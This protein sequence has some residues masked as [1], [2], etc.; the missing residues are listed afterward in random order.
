MGDSMFEREISK[1]IKGIIQNDNKPILL[2]GARQVGKTTVVKS[3]CNEFQSSL[4]IN[5]EVDSNFV[6]I[7]EESNLDF[8]EIMR[9]YALI[10]G[11]EINDDTLIVFDE[12]Q[13]CGKLL[14]GLK[15]FY[16][17]KV[18]NTI[19]ATGSNLGVSINKESEWSFP[20]GKVNSIKMFPMTF[21]EFLSASNNS[22][23]IDIIKCGLNGEKIL[24]VVH[25]SVL[26]LFDI[27]INIGGMPEVVSSFIQSEDFNRVKEI[28]NN[29]LEGYTNDILKYS[30]PKIS[31]RIY[32]I[33]S[34]VDVMLASDT[35]KFKIAKIDANTYKDIV[36]PLS[37]LIKTGLVHRC[38]NV[39][40][41]II[42][43]RSH[44]KENNFKLFFSDV[45]LLMRRSNY[46]I[47]PEVINND[48]IYL[49]IVMENYFATILAYNGLDLIC[50]KRRTTEIDFLIQDNTEVIPIEVKSGNN[51]QA[52]SLR[53]YINSNNP[54]K[55]YKFSRNNFSLNEIYYN[56]PVYSFEFIDEFI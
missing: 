40:S 31:S 43:L 39:E 33:Y 24:D 54:K 35:Q 5:M 53:E 8:Y 9:S 14:T 21:N 26:K 1:K 38:D 10:T 47:S 15:Y 49:G 55:A 6:K 7:V 11:K 27:Y 37:W 19:I 16:E 30:E 25:N 29:I 22:K 46:V 18:P 12:I 51:T 13:F 44:I 23:Y 56:C 3:L 45:G 41:S 52:K 17:A 4:Y 48:K 36:T 42:P 28:Q 20:V 50:Y 34:N 32:D 2:T